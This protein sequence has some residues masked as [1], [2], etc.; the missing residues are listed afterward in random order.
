MKNRGLRIS[1]MAVLMLSLVLSGCSK[2]TDK[3][4]DSKASAAATTAA[5]AEK[6]KFVPEKPVTMMVGFTPGGST[7]LLAR[8]IEKV[9][10]MY[11]PQQ[12][13]LVNKSGAGGVEGATFVARSKPDGYT[14]LLGYGSSP[15]LVTPHL[16]K[17]EYDPFKDLTGVAR[18]SIHSLAVLVKADS[19]YKTIADVVAWAKKENKPVTAA[20]S[21]NAGVSD[22]TVRG[23]GKVTGI[24]V[25]PVPHSGS[26]GAINTLLGGNTII[27]SGHPCEIVP[28]LK[29]GKL[30]PIGMATKERDPVLPDVPTLYEQGIPFHI[31]GSVKGIAVNPQTPKEIKDYYAELFK[32]I[33]EDKDFIKAMN[34]MGQPIQYQ[35]TDDFNKFMKQAYEDYAKTIKDLDIK[36]Q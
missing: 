1:C 16:Q 10:S 12:V 19:P 3:K 33:C 13:L 32:K 5:S 26:A 22:I 17:M 30:R 14:L 21:V 20:V 35:G 29:A 8:A 34:D 4:T 7:D 18:I 11:C 36:L 6:G 15:E 23:I 27:G 9:W 24:Q 2:T 28:Q 31:W 25:T